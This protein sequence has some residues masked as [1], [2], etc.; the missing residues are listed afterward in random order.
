[1]SI[2]PQVEYLV[3][4]DTYHDPLWKQLCDGPEG[5][6]LTIISPGCP[7]VTGQKAGR[8]TGVDEMIARN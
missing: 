8:G 4:L 1:M 5:N 7:P 3:D 6:V 2:D